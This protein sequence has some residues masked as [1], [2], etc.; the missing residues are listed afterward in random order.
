MYLSSGPYFKSTQYNYREEESSTNPIY[1]TRIKY[2][3]QLQ[4]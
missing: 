1:L 4:T 3:Q 2:L